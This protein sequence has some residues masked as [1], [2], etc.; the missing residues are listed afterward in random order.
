MLSLS[1]QKTSTYTLKDVHHIC[2]LVL[3]SA[4]II[5][6][7]SMVSTL[8]TY[9]NSQRLFTLLLDI[10]LPVLCVTSLKTQHFTEIHSSFHFDFQ[11]CVYVCV[12]VCFNMSNCLNWLPNATLNFLVSWSLLLLLIFANGRQSDSPYFFFNN[13]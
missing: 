6:C 10:W 5:T 3:K 4:T 8:L 13:F 1:R 9:G 7:C 12:C 11:L 2:Y